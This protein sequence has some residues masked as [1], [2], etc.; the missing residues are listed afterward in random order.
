MGIILEGGFKKRPSGMGSLVG[1]ITGFLTIA[2]FL[3]GRRYP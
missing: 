2:R 3:Q 1:G